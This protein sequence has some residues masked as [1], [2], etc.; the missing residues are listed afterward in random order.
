MQQPAAYG[1][2]VVTA[3]SAV[4]IANVVFAIVCLAFHGDATQDLV[5]Q[6][7]GNTL[8]LAALKLFLC[9]DLFFTFPIVF[10]S[11]RQILE[12]AAGIG[13]D[14]HPSDDTTTVHAV[15]DIADVGVPSSSSSLSLSLSSSRKAWQ[16][17]VLVLAAVGACFGLAQLGGFGQVA[18]LVGGVAQGTLAFIMPPAIALTMAAKQQKRKATIWLWDRHSMVHW[19]VGAFGV[20]VV[21]SVTY[22]TAIG[23]LY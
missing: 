10:S 16:R 1:T 15:V 12:N 6:N 14:N 4:W 17:T 19:L 18:N 22:S 7:L 5:L 11:G 23:L 13:D 9:V 21:S 3:V 8:Y 20:V 2:A